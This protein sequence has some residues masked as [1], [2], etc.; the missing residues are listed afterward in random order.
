MIGVYPG[1]VAYVWI[2]SELIRV[3]AVA[4]YR[5]SGMTALG[6]IR[7]IPPYK[8]P[9]ASQYDSNRIGLGVIYSDC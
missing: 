3:R 8:E 1:T 4:A 9:N 2:S 7:A 6:F 5:R